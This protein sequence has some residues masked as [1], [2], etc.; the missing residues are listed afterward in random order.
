[1]ELKYTE[2]PGAAL[3]AMMLASWL[4]LLVAAIAS[5]FLG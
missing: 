1:M 3:V 4:V 2:V 5:A